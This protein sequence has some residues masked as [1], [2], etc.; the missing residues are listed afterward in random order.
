MKRT[1]ALSILVILVGATCYRPAPRDVRI[2]HTSPVADSTANERL[3]FAFV[4]ADSRGR[5]DDLTG[6]MRVNDGE[7][8]TCEGKQEWRNTIDPDAGLAMSWDAS[9]TRS[10]WEYVFRCPYDIEQLADGEHQVQYS[11]VTRGLDPEEDELEY[12]NMREDIEFS[13]HGTPPTVYSAYIRST[14]ESALVVWDVDPL[15]TGIE[16]EGYRRGVRMFSSRAPRGTLA[17]APDMLPPGSTLE[18][19]VWDQHGNR[20]IRELSVP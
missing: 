19:R 7:R 10:D 16:V 20:T 8:I 3:F 14:P 18:L 15:L 2:P 1:L 11:V 12:I 13:Y 4:V 9:E 17:L 5:F 6:S